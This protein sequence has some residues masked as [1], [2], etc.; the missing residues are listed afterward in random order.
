MAII[1]LT[2]DWGTSDY[3]LAA[4]KGTILSHLPGASIID[5]SHH[6][7]QFDLEGAAFT[8]R[9]CFHNFPV[10]TIHI[11]AI[12]TEESIEHPHVA[13][14]YKGHYFIGTDNGIFSMILGEDPEE[15]AEIDIPQDS[16]FFT[17]STRDRFVKAAV[18]I[19]RG[20][21]IK[22][23]GEPR[24]GLTKRLLFK[25]TIVENAIKGMVIHID[26]YENAITNIPYELFRK[27]RKGRAFEIYFAGYRIQKIQTGY[28]DVGVADLLAIFGTHGMLEIAMNQ[29][30]AA[31]LCGLERNT[32]VAIN[33]F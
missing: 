7:R 11:V 14:L 30:K 9:N 3:Y 27:E 26:A 21:P 31:S 17:F 12:N 16:N 15:M 13:M 24:E 6:I 4:V 20:T 19:V 5:I 33:F 32:P 23:L 18:E 22:D 29:G 28:M 1:T 2:S 8:I 10:G 25:P